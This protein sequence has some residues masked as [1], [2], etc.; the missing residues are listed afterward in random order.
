MGNLAADCELESTLKVVLSPFPLLT[1]PCL[2]VMV[3]N[4]VP[5]RAR[6]ALCRGAV[7]PA[8]SVFLLVTGQVSSPAAL[9]PRHPCLQS[10]PMLHLSWLEQS[11]AASSFPCFEIT[12]SVLFFLSKVNDLLTVVL[13]SLLRFSVLLAFSQSH[14]S[15][16]PG[17][18]AV[19]QEEHRCKTLLIAWCYPT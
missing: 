2:S 9:L 4:P 16:L 3:W 7:S 17:V 18:S 1:A 19:C 11:A 5:L 13:V 8:W 14:T 10:V 15:L 12:C 6:P